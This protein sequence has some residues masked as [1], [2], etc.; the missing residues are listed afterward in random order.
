M[1]LGPS[2]VAA[3]RDEPLWLRRRGLVHGHCHH[4]TVLKRDIDDEL[5]ECMGLDYEVLDS[6]CCGMA[7]AFG[8]EAGEKSEVSIGAGERVLLPAVRQAEHETLILAD[9]FSCQSQITQC[10]DREPLHLAQVVQMALRDGKRSRL[11]AAG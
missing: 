4:K 7:G 2:C 1:G 10:T 6:G 3:F 9:G 5:M 8:Y 11:R